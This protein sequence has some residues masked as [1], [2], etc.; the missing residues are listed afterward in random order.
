M[1]VGRAKTLRRARNQTRRQLPKKTV[2]ITQMVAVPKMKPT[3]QAAVLSTVKRVLNRNAENKRVSWIG[4]SNVNHNSP[5]GPADC[6][7]LIQSIFQVDPTAGPTS[8]QREGDRIKP[9]SLVVRGTLGMVVGAQVDTRPIYVRVM[10]LQQKDIRVGS[11]VSGGAVDTSRLLAPNYNYLPSGVQ[12]IAFGGQALDLITPINTDKF[13]VYMD[14]LIKLS[15]TSDGVEQNPSKVTL[16]SYRFKQLPSYLTFD[17][18]NG[19]YPNNFAPFCCIGYSY[20]DGSVPDLVTLR[21]N[22]SYHSML[23]FEDV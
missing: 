17:E 6:Q 22:S 3:Q 15:P 12:Q 16:W 20:A 10:I 23:T 18:G 9:R 11:Q 1:P 4:E 2:K 8:T 13:R 14:R 21:L 5:I 7:P 19:D